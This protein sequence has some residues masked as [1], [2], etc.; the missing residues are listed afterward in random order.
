M[1]SVLVIDE[2]TAGERSEGP[3]LEFLTERVT[4]RELIR[5]RV[6]Q[7]V[8]EHNARQALGRPMLVEPAPV[9]RAL[10]GER[11]AA[12]RRVDWER[13]YELALRAFEGNGFLLFAGG[14]QLLDLD[15]E[16]ELRHDTEISFLRLVPLVGG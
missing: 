6:Y 16:I 15:E 5:G 10:N 7:E 4:V 14:R 9:E 13:Q 8:T 11:R 12:G 2:T 1:A 3:V